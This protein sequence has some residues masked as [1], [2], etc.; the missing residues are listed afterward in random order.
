[1]IVVGGVG[2]AI[3]LLFAFCF[4]APNLLAITTLSDES[5]LI[6][7]GWGILGFLFFLYLFKR[8]DAHRLGHSTVTWV[9]LLALIIFT[10]TVWVRQE[11]VAEAVRASD[12]LQTVGASAASWEGSA[13]IEDALH[14]VSDVATRSIL[15]Q[16]WLVVVALAILFQIYSILQKRERQLEVEKALAE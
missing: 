2:L 16:T 8:D 12:H 13:T 7:A 11:T 14:G 1:M 15:I 4:L 3:S 9:V 10:S 5:Y 6:L